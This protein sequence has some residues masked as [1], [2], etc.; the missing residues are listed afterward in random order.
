[1]S[2]DPSPGLRE[3]HFSHHSG[4][5]REQPLLPQVL[6]FSQVRWCILSRP[7]PPSLPSSFSYTAGADERNE[8]C[9]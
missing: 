8:D 2:E 1:M 3:K 5:E 9:I 7:F 4:K 6:F